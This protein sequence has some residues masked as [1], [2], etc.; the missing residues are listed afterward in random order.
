MPY[1]FSKKCFKGGSEQNTKPRP[2]FL[3]KV[4]ARQSEEEEELEELELE[5]AWHA[6]KPIPD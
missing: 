3:R 1:L 6:Q 4:V 5:E 2:F